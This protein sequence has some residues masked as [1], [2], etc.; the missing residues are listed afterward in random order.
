LDSLVALSFD[1]EDTIQITLDQVYIDLNTTETVPLSEEDKEQNKDRF[2]GRDDRPLP[3]LEATA[4]SPQGVLLGDPG[5]GKSSFVRH[6]AARLAAAALAPEKHPPPAGWQREDGKAI[7]PLLTILRD[8]GPKLAELDLDGKGFRKQ[9]ALLREAVWSQWREDLQLLGVPQFA[10]L[11]QDLLTTGRVLLI[12]DGLDEVAAPIRSRLNQAIMAIKATYDDLTNLA[13]G[14]STGTRI[15]VTCRIRSYPID[16]P[17]KMLLPG[18]T[19]YTLASFTKEQVR[20][21]VAAWYNAT[22]I[23]EGQRLERQRDLQQAATTPDLFRLAR[24]PMLLTTMA[25]IHQTNTELP[26]E[27]VLLYEQA[28]DILLLRWQKHRGLEISDSLKSV[29]E[30]KRKMRKILDRLGYESHMLLDPGAESA[31]LTRKDVI[32]IL[33]KDIY[34]GNPGL[35]GEFLN[36]VDHRA[37]LLVG[38]GGTEAAHHPQ[39]YSFPHRTFLQY[40]AG[41]YL[42]RGRRKDVLAAFKERLALGSDW[43]V[44]A[45]MG[46]EALL[47]ERDNDEGFL[48]LAYGLCPPREPTIEAEWRGIVWSGHMAALL[49]KPEI[50]EDDVARGGGRYLERLRTR[51]QATLEVS[52]LDALERVEAGYHLARLGDKRPGVLDVAQME[53]CYVPGGPFVM[54]EG[55]NQHTNDTLQQGYWIGRFP[56]TQAHF[57]QFIDAG[58]YHNRDYWLEAIRN[59]T[60]REPGEAK[61]FLDDEW[62]SAPK[63]Y[64]EPF[65]LANYPVVGIMWYEMQAF[66]LWLNTVIDLPE[67]YRI[68]LP[69]EAEWEKAARGGTKLPPNADHPSHQPLQQIAS[70]PNP[71]VQPT[72]VDNLRQERLYPWGDTEERDR[73]APNL[74]NYDATQI[75]STSAVGAFP[76]GSSPYGCEELSGNVWE[77][78]RSRHA[79]YPYVPEDGRETVAEITNSTG[80]VLRGGAYY[81]TRT[82]VRCAS[83]GRYLPHFRD[84]NFGFR[85]VLSPFISDL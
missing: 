39:L 34:L 8:L 24:N 14:V 71:D 40:L 63:Q 6:L 84:L 50:E 80:I 56:V 67:G 79:G 32:N 37:G 69:S 17:D 82:D 76:Q 52:P 33:E 73:A 46:A 23:P 18:F 22:R 19:V 47:F 54:G 2:S 35:A 3:V 85:V 62:R 81:D 25:L 44:A 55:K 51:L 20:N 57:Q 83:R 29:L 75:G 42:V 53:M 9:Q 13:D 38:R 15:I 45:Q 43:Y 7:I 78:T 41:C 21:F 1:L 70:A 72:F 4:Q 27:R 68:Q 36:Y 28:V 49:D 5:S 64:R 31:D 30:D 60:W 11:L 26:R 12:F 65:G 59:D 16:E 61:G 58:G 10:D 48:D 66:T 77:W 74:T